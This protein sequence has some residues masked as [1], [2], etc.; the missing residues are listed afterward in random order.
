MPGLTPEM[1][2][3]IAAQPKEWAQIV[4]NPR[5]FQKPDTLTTAEDAFTLLG[6]ILWC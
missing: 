6:R 2:A 5:F 3:G 4:E 1:L